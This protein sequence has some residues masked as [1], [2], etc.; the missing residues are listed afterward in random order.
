MYLKRF[1]YAKP[2]VLKYK[3]PFASNSETTL[4]KL[5]KFV[6]IIMKNV[7]FIAFGFQKAEKAN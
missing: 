6:D 4:V 1:L 5:S 7:C 3:E 2:N